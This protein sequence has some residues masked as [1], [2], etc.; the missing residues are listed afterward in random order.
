MHNT[1]SL[2]GIPE[3]LLVGFWPFNPVL[4]TWRDGLGINQEPAD[5]TSDNRPDDRLPSPGGPDSGWL[6][7]QGGKNLFAMV[8][9]HASVN[10]SLFLFPTYGSHCNPLVGVGLLLLTAAVIADFRERPTPL[11]GPGSLPLSPRRKM[12]G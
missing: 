9:P 2:H 8:L 3:I 12:G 7:N 1:L 11:P 10:V 6:Y 5:I 4:D